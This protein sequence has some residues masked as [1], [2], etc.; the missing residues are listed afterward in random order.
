V[1]GSLIL[2]ALAHTFKL[3]MVTSGAVT[4]PQS[5]RIGTNESPIPGKPSKRKR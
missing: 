5:H 4:P 1:V 2:L 3:R